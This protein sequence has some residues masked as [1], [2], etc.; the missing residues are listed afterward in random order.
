MTDMNWRAH[1]WVTSNTALVSEALDA[2]IEDNLA[3]L[4]QLHV[5]GD[6]DELDMRQCIIDRCQQLK[7]LIDSGSITL[8]HKETQ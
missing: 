7:E 2:T 5:N 3:L 6:L 1:A 8:V 4:D